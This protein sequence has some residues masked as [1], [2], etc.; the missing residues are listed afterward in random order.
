MYAL[1]CVCVCVS[2]CICVCVSHFINAIGFYCIV[3]I[4]S[5]HSH[6]H[7]RPHICANTHT[8][9]TQTIRLIANR[10]KHQWISI[11]QISRGIHG[12]VNTYNT[13]THAHCLSWYLSEE[14]ELYLEWW[15]CYFK[16]FACMYRTNTNTYTHTRTT[17]TARRAQTI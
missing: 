11:R 10:L 3:K 7:S 17:H 1:H 15:C 5:S 9:H 4:D 14:K 12:S 2:E 16:C 6:T 8:S 13:H